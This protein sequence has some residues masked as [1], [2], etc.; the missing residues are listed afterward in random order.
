MSVINTNV[1]AILTQNALSKNERCHV[2]CHGAV[3]N[4]SSGLICG[5]RCAGTSDLK[6]NDCSNQWIKSISPERK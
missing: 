5:R 4:W 2:R 6:P 1:S 3:I